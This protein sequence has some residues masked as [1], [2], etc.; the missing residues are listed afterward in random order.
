M[1]RINN[2]SNQVIQNGIPVSGDNPLPTQTIQGGAVISVTNR[3]PSDS[4]LIGIV[5]RIVL[6]ILKKLNVD[7]AGNLRVVPSSTPNMT[8]L[9]TLTNLTNWGLRTATTITQQESFIAFQ[10]SYRRNLVHS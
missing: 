3:V 6:N 5:E 8:T 10:Q 1:S 2:I 9:G 7:S 4:A